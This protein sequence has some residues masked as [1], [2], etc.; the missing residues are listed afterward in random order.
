MINTCR[1]CIAAV[2]LALI[3][4]ADAAA[5]VEHSLDAGQSFITAG[6]IHLQESDA[7]SGV[8]ERKP[9]SST[10]LSQMQQL[11]ESD[12]WGQPLLLSSERLSKWFFATWAEES[13]EHTAF[14]S[15]FWVQCIGGR[16]HL[17]HH[18][19]RTTLH[20]ICAPAS[21]HQQDAAVQSGCAPAHKP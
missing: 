10:Q 8:F 3:T 17:L 20:T 13:N 4:T 5:L 16:S 12:R 9:L 14:A 6:R 18:S 2:L 1:A 15:F 19:S 21:M 11:V 7:V